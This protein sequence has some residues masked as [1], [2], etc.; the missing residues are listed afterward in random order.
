MDGDGAHLSGTRW[1]RFSWQSV[2][3]GLVTG[4]ASVAMMYALVGRG[5]PAL[6]DMHDIETKFRDGQDVIVDASL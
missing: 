2:I 4:I 3:A 6:V 1:W 5:I